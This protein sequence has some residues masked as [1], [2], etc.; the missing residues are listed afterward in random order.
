MPDQHSVP[1]EQEILAV[2]AVG[3]AKQQKNSE[4]GRQQAHSDETGSVAINVNCMRE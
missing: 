2:P 3:G 1:A 4:A